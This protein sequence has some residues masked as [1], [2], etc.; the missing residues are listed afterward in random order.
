M[1]FKNFIKNI[2]PMYYVSAMLPLVIMIAIFAVREIYP[3]G[4]NCYLRSDM[5]HQYCPFFAELWYKMRTGGSLF[6]TWD[7]GLGSNFLALY[8]YY[9]SSPLNWFIVL[10]PKN[11][12]IELMNIII[13]I[14]LS[15]SSITV[16]YY[17]SKR[18]NRK[19]LT[20]S[21]FGLFYALGGYTAAFSWNLMWFDCFFLLPL[22]LLGLERLVFEDKGILYTITLGLAILSNYYIAIMICIALVFYF[23]ALL[24]IMPVPEKKSAYLLKIGYFTIFS[25]LA[26]GLSAVILLPEIYALGLTAS[27]AISFPKTLTQY[28]SVLTVITRQLA[29]T[30][31]SI[32][33]DHMPNI[34]CSVA[35]FLLYPLYIFNKKVPA[36]E[37]AAKTVLLLIFILAFSLNIP[38]FIWHGFHYP[39]S[40]PA[41]QSFIYMFI[42]LTMCFDG[43]KDMDEITPSM[44]TKSLG[45]SLIYLL[46]LDHLEEGPDF[47]LLGIN[48]LFLALYAMIAIIYK[49]TKCKKYIVIFLLFCVASIECTMNM[50]KTGYSTTGR[51]YYFKDYDEVALL[52]ENVMKDDPS[53]YR[54]AKAFG[55]RSKDDA[56]WHNFPNGSAFTSTA[57]A[58]ITDLYGQL[59]LE[60]SMNAYADHGATAMVYSM[61]DIKYILSNKALLNDPLLSLVD[62][63]GEEYLYKCDYTLPL[64]YMV[65]SDINE[66]WDRKSTNPFTVQNN[67]AYNTTEIFNMFE[68]VPHTDDDSNGISI[69]P[70][71][72][73]HI[74][75]YVSNKS[76][77]SCVVNK[78]GKDETYRGIN[79]GRIIDLGVCAADQTV[80]IKDENSQYSLSPQCYKINEDK[81]RHF[82]SALNEQGLDITKHTDTKIVGTITVTTE[83]IMMTSIPYDPSWS[84]YVDGKKVELVEVAE[85]LLGIEL[86]TGTHDIVLKYRPRGLILGLLISLTCVALLVVAIMV[87]RRNDSIDS[88]EGN[89]AYI[90][91]DFENINPDEIEYIEAVPTENNTKSEE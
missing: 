74:Y 40:L 91:E 82:F 76:V 39:N 3:F 63:S 58:G 18:F 51:D 14:K 77:N 27:S 61:L 12:M 5:Y 66:A 13:L 31:V 49:K 15:L 69:T 50:E 64:G 25:L 17:L 22:I 2:H 41:R 65:R 84:A 23:I 62:Q 48:A 78:D 34:F 81:F 85:A 47:K 56:A 44:I 10:F 90:Q 6:Y 89:D 52:T 26:G 20:L 55:Y 59:G 87:Y 32:G 33:L 72:T 19:S 28:F 88:E 75:V 60:H 83:G 73:A 79:H 42:L 43:F 9:L 30:E 16:T 24:I 45:I 68:S 7:V 53:F 21:L 38:N 36:R 54:I 71:E 11:T 8:G 67:F 86:T 1:K 29:N 37:K 70:K 46:Y 57:Y 80:T 4:H 35:V